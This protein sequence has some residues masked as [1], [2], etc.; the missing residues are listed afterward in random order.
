[1]CPVREIFVPTL[2]WGQVLPHKWDFGPR[3]SLVPGHEPW[4]QEAFNIYETSQS[5]QR[6]CQTSPLGLVLDRGKMDI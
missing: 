5:S 1:M 4:S 6:R 2:E 3:K